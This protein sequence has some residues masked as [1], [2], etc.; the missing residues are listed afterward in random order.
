ME[1]QEKSYWERLFEL[2]RAPGGT[3]A[4]WTTNRGLMLRPSTSL[5]Y[6]MHRIDCTHMPSLPLR[7]CYYSLISFQRLYS[8]NFQCSSHLLASLCVHYW[9]ILTLSVSKGG[10]YIK[11][12]LSWPRPEGFCRLL[13]RDAVSLLQEVFEIGHGV[14]LNLLYEGFY[15]T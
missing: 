14:M 3:T 10:I 1:G 8:D 4:N 5:Y 11:Q 9:E 7:D 12:W 15:G 6:V 2:G 13:S